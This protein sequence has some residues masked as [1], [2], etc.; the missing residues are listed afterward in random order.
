MSL[1]ML[2]R[3]SGMPSFA[4]SL[5]VPLLDAMA[6]FSN[7]VT[8]RWCVGVRRLVLVWWELFVIPHQ[9]NHSIP[10]NHSNNQIA[11]WVFIALD[12]STICF[13]LWPI[14]A[15]GHQNCQKLCYNNQS[16]LFSLVKLPQQHGHKTTTFLWKLC[17][18]FQELNPILWT[19]LHPHTPLWLHLFL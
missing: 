11:A 6:K 9:Q 2:N 3:K 19:H 13:W 18:L 17:K 5:P 10:W 14:S 16:F 7:E 8:E 15:E 12:L 4:N 1:Y